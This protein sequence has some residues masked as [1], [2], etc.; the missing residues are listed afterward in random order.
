ME[1]RSKRRLEVVALFAHDRIVRVLGWQTRR[2][3]ERYLGQ[4]RASDGGVESFLRRES[5]AEREVLAR[6]VV[7]PEEV[8]RVA[9]VD[10][11]NPIRG[12]KRRALR[13]ADRD[14]RLLGKARIAEALVGLVEY[15]VERGDG[16]NARSPRRRQRREARVV[17]HHVELVF[18]QIRA[19]DREGRDRSLV[20]FVDDLV[21]RPMGPMPERIVERG[22]ELGAGRRAAGGEEGHLMAV[23]D[24]RVGESGQHAFGAPISFGRDRLERWRQQS[25]SHDGSWMPCAPGVPRGACRRTTRPGAPRRCAYRNARLECDRSMTRSRPS[26]PFPFEPRRCPAST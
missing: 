11:G 24:E 8:G 22:H 23:I 9:V 14:E 2:D 21:G 16:R 12:Q 19:T 10:G 17:V 3:L 20:G 18:V 1:V 6:R 7:R 25:D 4:E 5:A 13:V 26:S 15:P